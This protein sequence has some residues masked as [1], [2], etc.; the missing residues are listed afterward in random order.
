VPLRCCS[1][2]DG[3]LPGVGQGEGEGEDKGNFE[4][5]GEAATSAVDEI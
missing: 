2:V 4:G 1:P 3:A 5:V